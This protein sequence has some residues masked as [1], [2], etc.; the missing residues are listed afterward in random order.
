VGCVTGT[1]ATLSAVKKSSESVIIGADNKVG[2]IWRLVDNNYVD[3]LESDSVMD[4]VYA[5]I[6]STLD[7][8]SVYLSRQQL[9]RE[10]ETLRGNFEGVGIVLRM[11]NDTVCV[12][13]LIADG[14]SEKAGIMAGDRILKVDGVTV[15]GVKMPNDSVVQRLRGPRRSIAK[16]EIQRLSEPEPRE[17]EVRRDIINTPSVTYSGMIDSHTGYIKLNQFSGTTYDEFCDATEKLKRAGMKRM[18]LDLRGNSGG[19]LNAA[20]QICDEL[21][22]GR[23]RIVYTEGAHQRRKDA[24]SIPGGLFSE[25]ELTVLIDEYSAS[26]SEVVAGA[27]Q[28]NDRGV[29]AGRRSF[30]KGLVQQQF[31]L[32]DQTAV[33]LTIARYYTPSGRCIQRPYDKGNDAYY[34]DFIQQVIDE[35]ENDTLLSQVTDSTPYYTKSGRVVYGGGGIIPDHII[36]LKTDSSIVYY[37]MLISR[38]ILNSHAFDIVSSE[39]AAIKSR[40]A[41]ADAFVA[42]YRISN[43]MLEQ[44]FSRGEKRGLRKNES[45]IRA[46]RNDIATR[47]KAEIGDMLYG[48]EVFYRIMLKEDPEV[49]EALTIQ[50]KKWKDKNNSK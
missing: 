32:P 36:H 29:I 40:Y 28:D 19:V 22:P 37:N 30:G 48:P 5:S 21:L 3:R 41:N 10:S 13:Q 17:V 12:A 45:Q 23:E 2:A 47:L 20:I 24:Y 49:R 35:Y 16:I 15:S 50:N 1:L 4:K 38:G 31:R 42:G 39:G 34:A 26:A 11:I 43:G 14:P 27:I 18:I 25:G 33:L 6:L 7:P 8:H 46:H 9:K 44:L